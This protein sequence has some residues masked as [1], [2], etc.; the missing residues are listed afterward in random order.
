MLHL[1]E[2]F[3]HV[4]RPAHPGQ[5]FLQRGDD[6]VLHRQ[7]AG[8]RCLGGIERL[9]VTVALKQGD[10]ARHGPGRKVPQLHDNGMRR[11]RLGLHAFGQL[12]RHAADQA[13]AVEQVNG[14]LEAGGIDPVQALETN[15]FL[16]GGGVV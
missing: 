11:K 13:L 16:D 7:G 9:G 8:R 3:T 4:R 5:N 15:H 1:L 2:I 14:G 10:D 12:R 6:R